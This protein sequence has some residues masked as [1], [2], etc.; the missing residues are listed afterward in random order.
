M[1]YFRNVYHQNVSGE[2]DQRLELKKC[3]KFGCTAHVISVHTE[4][5]VSDSVFNVNRQFNTLFNSLTVLKLSEISTH[6]TSNHKN[7]LCPI[8]AV[9]CMVVMPA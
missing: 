1:T 3:V 7:Q 6:L 4:I 5:K 8:E 2:T 9:R